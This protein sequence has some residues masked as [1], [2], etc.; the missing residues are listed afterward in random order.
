MSVI[1]I[2]KC[3]LVCFPGEVKKIVHYAH[4]NEIVSYLRLLA[5]FLSIF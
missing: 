5:Y 3:H 4:E 1:F 2:F